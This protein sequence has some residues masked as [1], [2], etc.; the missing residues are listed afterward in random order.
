M[1]KHIDTSAI[2]KKFDTPRRV[3]RAE[4]KDQNGILAQIGRSC[5][6]FGSNEENCE[7]DAEESMFREIHS[8]KTEKDGNVLITIT[9]PEYHLCY[10]MNFSHTDDMLIEVQLWEYLP[11]FGEGVGILQMPFNESIAT[12]GVPLPFSLT[13]TSFETP[14]YAISYSLQITA[15]IIYRLEGK[16]GKKTMDKT[17]AWLIV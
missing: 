6:I 1:S 12:D 13:I 14:V 9:N 5:A 11:D 16:G 15:N 17:F 3:I 10:K 7:K 8:K 2:I 4:L